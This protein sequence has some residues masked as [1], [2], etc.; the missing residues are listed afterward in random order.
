MSRTRRARRVVASIGA[1]TLA[2]VHVLGDDA[3]RDPAPTS[4]PPT[5]RSRGSLTQQ[6]PDGGFELTSFP[7]L[8]DPRRGARDRRGR[9]RPAPRGAR[10]RRST[11]SPRC[12]S[13]APAGPTPLDSLDA[14]AATIGQVSSCTAAAAARR[15]IV[16]SAPPLGS[17]PGGVRPGRRRRPRR[18]DRAAR[19][20]AARHRRPVPEAHVQ[21]QALR[22]ARRGR[23]V[24]RAHRPSSRPTSVPRSRRT[25][26]GT[27]AA[28][29][30]A[31]GYRP[32]HDRGSRS[33]RWSWRAC[34][35]RTPRSAPGSGFFAAQPTGDGAWQFFGSDDAEL[36]GDGDARHPGRRLRPDRRRAG[37]NTVAPRAVEQRRTRARRVAAH[38]SSRAGRAHRQSVRQLRREHVRDVAG[39]AGDSS[40]SGS[41]SRASTATDCTMPGPAPTRRRARSPAGGTM[42][43]TGS[44]FM[45]GATLTV[46]LHS[47]PV[48]LADRHRRRVRRVLRGRDDPGRHAR[49][50]ARDRRDRPRSRRPGARPARS[51]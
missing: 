51:P 23:A 24:W 35:A 42:V 21:R 41:R 11:R 36:D 8:R 2:H 22:A 26:D 44:G 46:E 37:A 34:P 4:R 19:R 45:P 3:R 14:F 13:A 47:D 43:I 29:R 12:T 17:R 33:R 27:S 49:R 32:R 38:R 20:R 10:A 50:G 48:V 9:P 15:T 18:P 28:T 5:R 16:L 6:Q 7:G 39:G 40:R 1:L 30:P 25:A 31:T